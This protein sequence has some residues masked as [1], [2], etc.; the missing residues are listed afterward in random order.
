MVDKE[1]RHVSME[2]F[3]IER[4]SS[5]INEVDMELI[6]QLLCINRSDISRPQEGE[7][8]LLVGMQ[9]AGFHP[10]KVGAITIFC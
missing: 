1:G 5:E 6:A 10:V 2:V 9:Y 3:G 7:I 4:I 8:D